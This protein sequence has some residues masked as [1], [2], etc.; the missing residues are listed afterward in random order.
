MLKK[1]I[2]VLVGLIFLLFLAAFLASKAPAVKVDPAVKTIGMNTPVTVHINSPHG[3]RLL[4]AS[5]EQNGTRYKVF[6]QTQPKR[7]NSFFRDTEAPQTVTIPVGKQQAGSLQDGKATLIIEAQANDFMGATAELSQPVD[8]ITRPPAVSADGEQHYINQGGSELV[9]FTASGYWTEAGVRVGKYTFRSFAMPGETD[10]NS[11]KRFA[12]FAFP[13]D[14]PAD[15]VPV[16]YARNPSGAEATARFWYKVFP[17]QFRARDLPVDDSFLQKVVPELDPNGSGELIDRFL[18][19]NNDMRRQNNQYLTDLRMKTEPT[20]LWKGPFFRIGKVESF[21]ADQRSYI[22]K[23]KKV[24]QQMHLGFDLSDVQAAPVK[25]AN[26]GKIIHAGPNGIYGNCVVVDHGYGLQS[27]Y[28]HMRQID[29]KVGDSVSKEQ[30]IGR[31]GATGLAGGDH[32]HFSMQV[33][34]VQVNPLEWWDEHWIQDRIL[35]KLSAAKK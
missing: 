28:G 18:K 14:V 21:F 31:S 16:V 22:Y 23:G 6:E 29:V 4:A 13:W 11:S 24:D 9:T 7:A 5:L 33:D 15:T 25:A 2:A 8:V 35:S 1:L 17:K 26:S 20:I 32:I 30:V 10:P 12:V 19:I 3:V 34:G 27:I